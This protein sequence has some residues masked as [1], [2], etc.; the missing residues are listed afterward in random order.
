M[1]G[2]FDQDPGPGQ[3]D[4]TR[5]QRL[6]HPGITVDQVLSETEMVFGGPTGPGEASAD[7]RGGQVESGLLI[8]PA[9]FGGHRPRHRNHRL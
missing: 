4:V 9:G 6:P 8:P 7:L 3:V 5:I 2:L 1:A